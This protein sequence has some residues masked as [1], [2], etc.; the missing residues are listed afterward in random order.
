MFLNKPER[1]TYISMIVL[2]NTPVG[3]YLF[4]NI[5]LEIKNNWKQINMLQW[6]FK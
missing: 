4:E 1:T 3:Q 6:V 5:I 2:W